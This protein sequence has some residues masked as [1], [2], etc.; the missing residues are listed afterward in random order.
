MIASAAIGYLLPE[1]ASAPMIGLVVTAAD[2]T[3]LRP[4]IR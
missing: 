2:I 4:E 3:R 1:R